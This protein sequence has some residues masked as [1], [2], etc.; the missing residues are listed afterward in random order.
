MNKFFL[1]KFLLFLASIRNI[2]N[3]DEN[4]KKFKKI[5]RRQIAEKFKFFFDFKLNYFNISS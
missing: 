5:L 4:F 1:K 3:F 2:K